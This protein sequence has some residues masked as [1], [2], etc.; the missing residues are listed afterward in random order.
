[1]VFMHYFLEFGFLNF[2]SLQFTD[3]KR[4]N[5]EKDQSSID[6]LITSRQPY[7]FDVSDQNRLDGLSLFQNG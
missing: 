1:M 7:L 6:V 4:Q 3:K 5:E 2:I